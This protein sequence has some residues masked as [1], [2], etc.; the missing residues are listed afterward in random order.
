MRSLNF[1]ATTALSICLFSVPVI[2][3]EHAS[4]ATEDEVA[5]FAPL[6]QPCI[7]EPEGD[8]CAPVR[9]LVAACAADM[10]P[11]KCEVMFDDGGAV[12]EDSEL[13]ARMQVVL[14]N[15]EEA[16]PEFASPKPDDLPED[17]LESER[18]DAETE[19]LLGDENQMTH[20]TPPVLDGESDDELQEELKESD[21][22]S[23]QDDV[24]GEPAAP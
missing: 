24:D 7:A 18:I 2:A 6:V 4:D 19:L 10:T 8:A 1:Y 9:A 14:Q 16:M 5:L 22:E 12:F 23:P 3:S 17:V 11:Q 13:V 15:V 20:S 21:A